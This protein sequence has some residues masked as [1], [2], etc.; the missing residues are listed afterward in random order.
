M[1]PDAAFELLTRWINQANDV[2]I[3]PVKR[4]RFDRAS[5][6]RSVAHNHNTEETTK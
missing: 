1:D 5:Y 3:S 2:H 4:P 6:A